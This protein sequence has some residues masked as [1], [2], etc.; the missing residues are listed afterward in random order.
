MKMTGRKTS[1]LVGF[2]LFVLGIA[3]GGLVIYRYPIH[4][5]SVQARTNTAAAAA[6]MPATSSQQPKPPQTAPMAGMTAS[7]KPAQQDQTA[8][9]AS[10]QSTFT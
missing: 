8:S 2:A 4:E 7:D 10:P 1:F 6:A 5:R 9:P 3:T